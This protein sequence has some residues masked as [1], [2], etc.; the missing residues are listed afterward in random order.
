M[1]NVNRKSTV[2]SIIAAVVLVLCLGMIGFL[3]WQNHESKQQYEE[4]REEILSQNN[5]EN[6][7]IATEPVIPTDNVVTEEVTQEDSLDAAGEVEKEGPWYSKYARVPDKKVDFEALRE[8]NS[9]I[10]A[11][12]TIDDTKVDY[13][14][15]HCDEE[16]AFYLDHDI[17][18]KPSSEGMIFTD[19]CN[20]NDFSDPMTLIY[21]HNMKN[22]SMFRGLQSFRDGEFF[23]EHDTI[24]IYMDD[25]ELDYKIYGCFINKNEHILKENDFKDSL[26][27]YNYFEELKDRRDLSANFREGLEPA[28]GDHIITLVTCVGDKDRRLFVQGILTYPDGTT[29]ADYE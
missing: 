21:G 19:T 13:P 15:A 2:V 10:Y 11:W 5:E 25:V 22:G 16:T 27:F 26:V 28:I 4:L 7:A 3:L 12:I 9:D 6:K 18:G 23:K 17:D 8:Q 24:K 29:E 14:I 20:A 1:N